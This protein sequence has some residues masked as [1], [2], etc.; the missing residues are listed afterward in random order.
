VRAYVE[1]QAE[2]EVSLSAEIADLHRIFEHIAQKALVIDPTLEKSVRADEVKTVDHLQQWESRLM[3]AEKQKHEVT[4]NQLRALKEK[5]FPGNGLQERSDNFIPYYLKYGERF[6]DE[7]KAG[8][9]P[10]DPGFVLLEDM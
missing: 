2:A 1:A 5:L 4:L 7:L 9:D 8:L 3:R 6:L 10:F